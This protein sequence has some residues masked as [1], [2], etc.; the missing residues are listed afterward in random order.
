MTRWGRQ[1]FER[2]P[3]R[4]TQNTLKQEGNEKG[5]TKNM[6][7]VGKKKKNLVVITQQPCTTSNMLCRVDFLELK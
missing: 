3:K 5:L 6:V 4:T 7:T 2:F 1:N